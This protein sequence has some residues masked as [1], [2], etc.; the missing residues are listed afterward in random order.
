M[1]K[2]PEVKN[3]IDE[4]FNNINVGDTSKKLSDETLRGLVA[5]FQQNYRYRLE[6]EEERIG[7][8]ILARRQDVI[9]KL[10]QSGAALN[11]ATAAVINQYSSG[12]QNINFDA[13]TKE[14]ITL[15]ADKA[16]ARVVK[17]ISYALE[18]G[19]I[20]ANRFLIWAIALTSNKYILESLLLISLI[21]RFG[22][23]EPNMYLLV[24]EY[25]NVHL[26]VYAVLEMQKKETRFGD[27]KV[28]RD[29]IEQMLL[30]LTLSNSKTTNLA[31][32]EEKVKFNDKGLPEYDSRILTEASKRSKAAYQQT[33]AEWLMAK[34][35]SSHLDPCET[36]SIYNS[37][38][39]D[40]RTPFEKTMMFGLLTDNIDYAF[41]F[42][43]ETQE[44][45]L[46][47]P[48]GNF[49]PDPVTGK[50]KTVF[51]PPLQP[52]IYDC[53]K[54][55]AVKVS[56]YLNIVNIVRSSE[57][58]VLRFCIDSCA[59]ELFEN[60][61]LRGFKMSYFTVNRL[62]LE[63]KRVTV[64]D[65][66]FYKRVDSEIYLKMLLYCASLGVR[67]DSYQLKIIQD[68]D[69]DYSGKHPGLSKK[70]SE[71]IREMYEQPLFKKVCSTGL[72]APMPKSL[73]LI[74]E[75]LGVI[76]S[77]Q[78][79]GKIVVNKKDTCEALY[80]L[81]ND[82]P[83]DSI[84]GKVN[85]IKEDAV[86]RIKD[87]I[88]STAYTLAEFTSGI[89]PI[90]CENTTPG[91][92]DPLEYTDA[93]LTYYK[94][95]KQKLYCF[96]SFMYED[97]E[98]NKFKNPYTD[99]ELTLEAQ[100]TIRSQLQVFKQLG[101]NPNKIIPI[102]TAAEMLMEK[103]KINNDNSNFAEQTIINMFQ[104]R[105]IPELTIKKQDVETYNKILRIVGMC[106]GYLNDLPS[107][108]H[109]FVTFCKAL[110]SYLKKNPQNVSAVLQ[111][112]TQKK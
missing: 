42:G 4:L 28:T 7:K 8:T 109:Q 74:A 30:L 105:G 25:G 9:D 34:G 22:K 101:V 72:K 70:P 14:N 66:K 54:F 97:I 15:G 89:L 36:L 79:S 106:Q 50:Y 48:K 12:V 32:Y 11:P 31:I 47:D 33:V 95:S 23:A 44:T 63:Y 64:S 61:L 99:E 110:Y 78:V 73:I 46:R 29:N 16:F 68:K 104:A 94:D 92:I 27:T 71:Q 91:N 58:D 2:E 17:R 96:P 13:A 82:G 85:R 10:T 49:I 56:K 57:S 1:S 112:I 52:G 62:V 51:S 43:T 77:E 3:S 93:A 84:E 103:D 76:Q 107:K 40:P 90:E 26:I 41:P 38:T 65:L 45:L 53:V 6:E 55:N 100:N 86:N 39:S 83:E 69:G 19:Y 81:Y 21:L 75:S 59:L 60:C 102:G 37:R 111:T 20:D 24:P 80:K 108:E 18:N 87:R 35:Y 88:R 5:N 67:I 98:S